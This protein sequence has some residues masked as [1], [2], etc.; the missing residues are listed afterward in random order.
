MIIK[1]ELEHCSDIMV[2]IMVHDHGFDD[3]ELRNLLA[4]GLSFGFIVPFTGLNCSN[5]NL[6]ELKLVLA[7]TEMD[8]A[9]C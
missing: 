5:L 7:S 8:L 4:Q 3:F 1:L 6:T 2:Y 9:Y